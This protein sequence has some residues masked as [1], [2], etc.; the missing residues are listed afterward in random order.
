MS[1]TFTNQTSSP[2]LAR[3]VFNAA[4]EGVD[5]SFE[6]IM[7]ATSAHPVTAITAMMHYLFAAL[8]RMDPEAAAV[9]VTGIPIENEKRD[10]DALM[11]ACQTLVEAYEAQCDRIEHEEA[12]GKLS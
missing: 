11:A 3:A 8:C 1:V 7:E 12:G 10:Q 5:R 2:E 9:V 6:E 4:A